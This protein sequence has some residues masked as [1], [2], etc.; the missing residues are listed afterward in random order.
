M[1][2]GARELMGEPCAGEEESCEGGEAMRAAWLMALETGTSSGEGKV[3]EA[4]V[5]R[6]WE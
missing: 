3:Y 2:L 4:A 5:R 6:V 1:P